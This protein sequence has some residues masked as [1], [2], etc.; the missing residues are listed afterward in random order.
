MPVPKPLEAVNVPALTFISVTLTTSASPVLFSRDT[1]KKSPLF[2][3]KSPRVGFGNDEI[4]TGLIVVIEELVFNSKV[5]NALSRY[6]RAIVYPKFFTLSIYTLILLWL[7]CCTST[8]SRCISMC[9]TFTT[10][11]C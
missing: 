5:E 10:N 9:M 4:L 8:Q 7:T 11:S 3:E 1:K 6:L 2:A